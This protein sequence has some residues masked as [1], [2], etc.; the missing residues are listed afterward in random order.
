MGWNTMN[1]AVSPTSSGAARSTRRSKALLRHGHDAVLRVMG[2]VGFV[3]VWWLWA[4]WVAN[5][6]ILP[7][8]DAVARSAVENFGGSAGLAYIGVQTTG[9]AANIAYTASNALSAW[10]AGAVIGVAVGLGSARLQLLR[11]VSD[12]VLFVFGSV[13]VLVA[14]PFFLIWFG[15]SRWGQFALVAFYCFAIVAVVAQSAALTL[16]PQCEEYAASLGASRWQRFRTVVAPACLPSILGGLRVALGSAWSLQVIAELLGSKIGVGRVIVVS[17][18]VADVAS[19]LA[20][21]IA[22]ALV[23]LICDVALKVVIRRSVRW[24]ET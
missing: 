12:P 8:P 16:A 1:V 24:Q 9:Y 3:A 7:T 2:V 20:I 11:N 13:P 22:L 15:F 10:V 17:A 4:T 14:A 6:A 5:P 18:S 21:I 19:V 23:A